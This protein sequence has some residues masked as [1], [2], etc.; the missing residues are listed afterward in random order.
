M[1]LR[2][3]QGWVPRQRAV[4][5]PALPAPATPPKRGPGPAVP[6]EPLPP[7]AE[8]AAGGSSSP[9]EWPGPN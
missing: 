5:R 7:L 4:P 3:G 1:A 8:S 9:R 6:P 2:A